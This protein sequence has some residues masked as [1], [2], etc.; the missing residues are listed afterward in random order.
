MTWLHPA[1]LF[2]FAVVA[3]PVLLHLLMRQK[4]KKLVFPALR[5]VEQRKRETSRRFRL[6]HLWLLILRM[7]ALAALVAAVARPTLPAANYNL[8]LRELLTLGGITAAG[9]ATYYVLLAKWRKQSRPKYEFNLRRARLRGW[10]T[11]ATL[12][13]ILLLVGWPYQRRIAAEITS[14]APTGQ[15]DLPV[16][17]AFVF[18]TSLSMQYTQEGKTRLEAA[19]Q[20]AS[21]HVRDFPSNSRLAITDTANDSPLIFQASLSAAQSR[22]DSLALAPVSMSLNERIRAALMLQA[23]DR[24]KTVAEMSSSPEAARRDRFIRRVY[25]FTDL[26]ATAWRL[27]SSRS[28][29]QELEK[30]PGLS[31]QV[32]DVGDQQPRNIGIR[33]VK[34]SRQRI[35]NGGT[36]VV[37]ADIGATGEGG[38]RKVVLAVN[39]GDQTVTRES[40]NPKLETGGVARVDFAMLT[41]LTGSVVHGEVRMES[42][43]PLKADDIRYFSAAIGAPPKVL[44]VS[45]RPKDANELLYALNPTESVSEMKFESVR[46][47]ARQLGTADLSKY[48]VIYLVNMRQLADD[49]WTKLGA[50]VEQGGGLA[51]VLGADDIEPV[52]YDR[53]AAQKFL[54]A[55][56]DVWKAEDV[57]FSIDQKPH[58]LFWRLRQ[59]E[60]YQSFSVLETDARVS[61]FWK[62]EPAA[63]ATVLATYTDSLRSPC[64]IDRPHGRG[65]TIMY[66]TAAHLANDPGL[67]WNTLPSPNLAPWL[68]I[69]F[70]EQMTEYLAR[71]T[72]LQFNVLAGEPVTLPVPPTDGEREYLIRRPGLTQAR[73][74]IPAAATSIVLDDTRD[75]GHYDLAAVGDKDSTAGFSVNLSSGESDFTRLTPEQ[76]EELFGKGTFQIARSLDELKSAVNISDL[77]KEVFPLVL[78]LAIIA[79]CGEH[80]VANW[81]Y[82]V[83]GDSRDSGERKPSGADAKSRRGSEQPNGGVARPVE[84]A[85][86]ASTA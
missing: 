11:G 59:Y 57:K 79:F 78:L 68:W 16:A 75:I 44:V 67:H 26:S 60:S 63:G 21:E 81:F 37:S 65:R 51:V 12:A 39:S 34:L 86:A 77:G 73:K 61:K 19:R 30:V 45:P 50:Y 69:A 64:L 47:D 48:D 74:T 28:I 55:R 18:D 20:M 52:A 8:N 56:L 70:V 17:A 32:V 53:P 5:L 33:E 15:F 4:P 27:G 9:I 6:R 25:V 85:A 58:A 76:L 2:G 71:T 66:T 31:I 7:A 42:S 46:I 62:T 35:P 54:P 13:A 41:N 29:Q 40:Q 23:D 14:P 10:A 49:T 24:A 72:D 1:L 84:P 3:A 80:F 36:L 22:M 38:E 43:D 83:D 82:D